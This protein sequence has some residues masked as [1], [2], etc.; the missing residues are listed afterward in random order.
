M[1]RW[2][3]AILVAGATSAAG[4][5]AI[6]RLGARVRLLSAFVT[7]LDVMLAEITFNLTPLPEL[8]SLLSR[9]SAPPARSF[10]LHC[11][12]LMKRLG[13]E[14]FLTLWQK[15]V[16]DMGAE[17][18]AGE[19]DV[20][21]DLGAVLGRYDHKAQA[22]AITLAKSRMEALLARAEGERARQGR[23]FGAL[24]AASGLAIVIILI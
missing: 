18:R 1:L 8:M 22:R 12:C 4:L 9:R 15:A 23:I 6:Q 17:W 7:A 19:R 2:L 16:G 10:F 20:L 24:G 3:G 11:A 5:A 14:P 21:M 13:E